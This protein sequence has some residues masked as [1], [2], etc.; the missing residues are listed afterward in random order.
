MKKRYIAGICAL[1][2]LASILVTPQGGRVVAVAPQGANQTEIFFGDNITIDS[3]NIT[4]ESGELT[5]GNLK[6]AIDSGATIIT[7][8]QEANVAD[9]IILVVAVVLLVIAYWHRDRWLY[10]LA[11]FGMLVYAISFMEES[12]ALSSLIMV[13][14]VYNFFKAATANKGGGNGNGAT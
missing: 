5:I 9:V 4:L 3:A 2:V 12:L 8:S 1:V 14:S 10:V 13:L 11:G 7:E 6:E